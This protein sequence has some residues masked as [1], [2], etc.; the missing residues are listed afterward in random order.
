MAYNFEEQEQLDDL[1]A[2]WNK[3][4]TFI[5]TCITI[6]AVAVAVWRVWQWYENKQ[7]GEAASTYE[8]VREAARTGDMSRVRVASEEL[9]DKYSSSVFASMGGLTAAHAHFDKK[10]LDSAAS[11]LKWV[12]EN[13]S[14]AEYASVARLRLAGVLL[15]QGKHDEGLAVLDAAGAVTNESFVGQYADRRG[16][17]LTALGKTDE[18]ITAYETALEALPN[19]SQL[20]GQVEL[21]LQALKTS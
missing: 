3:Y 15:D 4:G 11:A 13:A 9:F 19:T 5:L 1:K 2:W 16:D 8:V 6:V 14:Q 7:A 12:A 18:A 10:D 17:I 21:K 20:K